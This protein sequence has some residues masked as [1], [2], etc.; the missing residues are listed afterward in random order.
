MLTLKDHTIFKK[1]Y[2]RALF[3]QEPGFSCTRWACFLKPMNWNKVTLKSSL[4][5]MRSVSIVSFLNNNVN[6]SY[7]L[8]LILDFFFFSKTRVKSFRNVSFHICLKEGINLPRKYGFFSLATFMT[9]RLNITWKIY[10]HKIWTRIP[11][12]WIMYSVTVVFNLKYKASASLNL[13]SYWR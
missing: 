10:C 8:E 12:Y 2:E 13:P 5:W 3:S 6:A 7:S 11:E 1:E 9:T 4:Q